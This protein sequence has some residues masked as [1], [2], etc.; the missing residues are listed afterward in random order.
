MDSNL[1]I[2]R[3]LVNQ[4]IKTLRSSDDTTVSEAD[5]T[6]II[7]S[8]MYEKFCDEVGCEYGDTAVYGT[9]TIIIQSDELKAVS[10][11]T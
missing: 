2:T 7:T 10:F 11:M 1:E 3:L 9:K 5:V 4:V 6:T 8:A